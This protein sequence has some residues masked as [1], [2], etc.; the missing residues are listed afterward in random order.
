[1]AGQ[2]V[3]PSGMDEVMEVRIDARTNSCQETEALGIRVGDFITFDPR[4][5]LSE[6]G[7]IRSRHLDD[8]AGVAAI[9]G[10]LQAINAAD[11]NLKQRTTFHL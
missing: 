2:K 5:E 8:K 11:L 10:A 1:M 4:V 3:K 9:Y 6:M 7:F